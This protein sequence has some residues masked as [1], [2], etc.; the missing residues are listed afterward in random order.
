MTAGTSQ[1]TEISWPSNFLIELVKIAFYFLV[2]CEAYKKIQK[3]MYIAYEIQIV[4]HFDTMT[5]ASV[6]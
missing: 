2:S 6:Y 5:L 1:G 3:G 4:Q